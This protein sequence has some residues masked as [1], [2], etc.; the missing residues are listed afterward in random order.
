MA[1]SDIDQ[2]KRVLINCWAQLSHD[3]LNQATDQL[4]K[5]LMMVIKVN[6]A[7]AELHLDQC[8][9]TFSLKWNILQEF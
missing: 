9:S 4:P 7:H 6:G 3:T 8:F 5:R 2:L 1:N